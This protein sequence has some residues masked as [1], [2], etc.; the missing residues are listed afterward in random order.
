[1]MRNA[2]SLTTVHTHTH[3]HTNSLNA[4]K[5]ALFSVD[6][7]KYCKLKANKLV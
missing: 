6:K 3:T 7:N 5:V 1:M 2:E 4:I